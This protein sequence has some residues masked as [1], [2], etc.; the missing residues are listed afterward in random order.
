VITEVVMP[1]MGLEVTEATVLN[2]LVSVGDAVTADRVLFELETDKATTEV[3]A[4]R[5]GLVAAIEVERGDLVAVGAVLARLADR[6]DETPPHPPT[7]PAVGRRRVAP[8][9]RR[10]AAELGITLEAVTGTGP[11]GRVTLRDVEAFAAAGDGRAAW[12]NGHHDESLSTLRRAIARRMTASQLIPQYQLE[13]DVDAAHLLAQKQARSAAARS[14]ARVGISDLLIQAIAETVVRHPALAARFVDGDQPRLE[15][16]EGLGIGLAVATDRGLLVPVIKDAAE[17][18]LDHIAR[19]RHRLTDA[20]RS[21][22]LSQP[23]MSGGTITLSNLA[24]F[25]VDRFTAML[26]PG[27]SAIVAVGRTVA[28]VV[29]RE[30]GLAIMP[31]MTITMTFD[32]RTI[33]GAVGAAALATLAELLEGAMTWRP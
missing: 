21:G 14:A 18:G 8:V 23:E 10:A 3:V 11:R 13:R 32:H 20:A 27:E 16:R 12:A 19:E 7:T 1:Q 29:P 24:A 25:G 15:R 33:D 4:P 5:T 28:R 2:V 30:R 9:A 26:N 17:S 22:R 31:V 6:E